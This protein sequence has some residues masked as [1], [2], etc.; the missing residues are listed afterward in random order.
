MPEKSAATDA[1]RVVAGTP[2]APTQD[3]SAR[4]DIVPVR[5]RLFHT[6]VSALAIVALGWWSWYSD[7]DPNLSNIMAKPSAYAGHEVKIGDEPILESVEPGS[8][9]VQSRGYLF[10]VTGNVSSDDI[11]RFIYVRGIFHPSSPS[12]EVDAKIHPA[13]HRVARGRHAKIWIS[14]IPTLWIAALLLRHFRVNRQTLAI[15]ER[16]RVESLPASLPPQT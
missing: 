12:D 14:V 6:A 3:S 1:S 13:E 11:G 5:Q 10:H 4:N 16:H 9:V 2:A 7:P 8:F 15:E